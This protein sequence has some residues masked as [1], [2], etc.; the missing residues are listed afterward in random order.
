LF[1]AT[2]DCPVSAMAAGCR[3]FTMELRLGRCLVSA[4]GGATITVTR[5]LPA[6]VVFVVVTSAAG[7][8]GG[9]FSGEDDVGGA[10]WSEMSAAVVLPRLRN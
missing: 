8:T 2:S 3:S 5:R 1:I 6:L 10:K 7:C 9:S 4:S